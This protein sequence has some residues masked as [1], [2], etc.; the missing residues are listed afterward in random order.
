MALSA[1]ISSSATAYQEGLLNM[2]S[3][4][5]S[6]S[7]FL[8]GTII[9]FVKQPILTL[10]MLGSIIV[11]L[12]SMALLEKLWTSIQTKYIHS[13]DQAT[14]YATR[15]LIA[16]RTV[17]AFNTEKF[18]S[19][20]YAIKLN[21]AEGH[22]YRL[23]LRKGLGEGV[24]HFIIIACFAL[25]FWYGGVLVYNGS[26]TPGVILTVFYAVFTGLRELNV[27]MQKFTK[28]TAARVAM[29]TPLAIMKRLSPISLN[30]SSGEKPDIKGRVEFKNVTFAYPARP[31][32][33]ILSNLNLIIPESR[34]TAICGPSGCG[35]STIISLLARVYDPDRG[36]VTVDSHPLKTLALSH[37]RRQIAIVTQ[38]KVLFQGSIFDNI[39]LGVVT[40]EELMAD[41]KG[42]IKARV[43]DACRA[44]HIHAFIE[45]LPQKYDTVVAQDSLSGGQKQRLAIARAFLQQPKIL[46]LDEPTSALDSES[47][48]LVQQAIEALARGRTCIVIAHKLATIKKADQI[49][50]LNGGQMVEQGSHTELMSIKNGLYATMV[51]Q[52]QFSFDAADGENTVS[53]TSS[54]TVRS[55]SKLTVVTRRKKSG[56][57]STYHAGSPSSS[58]YFGSGSALLSKSPASA[59]LGTPVSFMGTPNRFT[60]TTASMHTSV[61]TADAL[62][63]YSA[64]INGDLPFGLN[65]GSPVSAVFSSVSRSVVRSTPS[66]MP[67]SHRPSLP[68]S[69]II[70]SHR[71]SLQP[72]EAGP[73][74]LRPVGLL[75][76]SILRSKRTTSVAAASTKS[77]ASN[78][79]SLTSHPQGVTSTEALKNTT[80]D[81]AAGQVELQGKQASVWQILKLSKPDAPLIFLTLLMSGGAGALSPI[82]SVCL[83]SL[84]IAYSTSPDPPSWTTIRLGARVRRLV[85]TAFLHQPIAW[86][87]DSESRTISWMSTVLSSDIDN[88]AAV[89]TSV[90]N[91]GFVTL[92]TVFGGLVAAFVYGWKMSLVGL[93]GIPALALGAKLNGVFIIR[94]E[95][96]VHDMFSTCDAE[97]LQAISNI[98]VINLLNLNEVFMKTHA[99]ELKDVGMHGYGV[100]TL[101]ALCSGLPDF[102]IYMIISLTLWYGSTLL[103][104]GEYDL[105]Q[106]TKVW[107]IL[108]G[109]AMGS[110]YFGVLSGIM[111][112]GAI[113][114]NEVSE[115]MSL[116]AMATTSATDAKP[117]R[118][119]SSGKVAPALGNATTLTIKGGPTTQ[120]AIGGTIETKNSYSTKSD[121]LQPS[122]IQKCDFSAVSSG[123]VSISFENVNF[124]YPLRP[125]I[126]ALIGLTMTISA[127]TSV[128]IVGSSGGGKS[129]LLALLE[130]YYEISGGRI[131]L[132]GVDIKTMTVEQTRSQI[133]LVSQDVALLEG[134][135]KSN[136]AYGTPSATME[137]VRNA[138]TAVKLDRF[139]ESLPEGYDTSVSRVQLSGGQRSRIGLARALVKNSPILL[140]DEPT[141]ALD[142]ISESE[143]EEALSRVIKTRTTILITHSMRTAR[144]ADKIAVMSKGEL[145]ETGTHQELLSRG[146]RDSGTSY[147]NLI[148]SGALKSPLS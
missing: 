79:T 66:L 96:I 51:E 103:I 42:E 125:S 131:L 110:S 45:T 24:S 80:Q 15:T 120:W 28:V 99:E 32:M 128:S 127:N 31:S 145:V 17:K 58:N 10:V 102:M 77:S 13:F 126:P 33:P 6:F 87:D 14:A 105:A 2:G 50:V 12:I 95:S 84:L 69:S 100:A 35:K 132:N 5:M 3:A 114:A 41:V 130:R 91:Q 70:P 144:I 65:Q 92:I 20:N 57:V 107:W 135:I 21:T 75:S 55:R 142:A 53:E 104:A 78:H 61:S 16:V 93:A 98:H 46:I 116:S 140:L 76:A 26:A 111:V 108:L 88:I 112:K 49:C 59:V 47:E 85:F 71:Q 44:A 133:A 94:Y 118:R 25:G 117:G 139:I 121:S 97:A 86:F 52:Q 89:L 54:C 18:E 60:P 129:T 119:S 137:D 106:M 82:F 74:L 62:R 146:P 67:S 38:D 9:A 37:Y 34:T 147:Y 48:T 90:L 63:R 1:S 11:L 143:V 109:S 64:P 141:A 4:S 39:I 83:S 19:A 115:V 56:N 36:D 68:S 81:T 30:S 43:V 7:T 124:S 40:S 29:A 73:F 23:G 138:A 27:A 134:T 22:D 72:T 122:Q 113:S 123:R 8:C 148:H 136:I 101:A